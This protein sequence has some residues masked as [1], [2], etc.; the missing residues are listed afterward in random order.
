MNNLI[1]EYYKTAL[2]SIKRGNHNGLVINAKPLYFLSIFS[3]IDR[4][5]EV[6]DNKLFFSETLN[7]EYLNTCKK[8]QPEIEP[9]PFFKPFYYSKSEPF[10]H[11]KYKQTPPDIGPS[12]RYIREYIDYAYLD[13]AL[14]DLLQ[15]A[16]AREQYKEA[17]LRFFWN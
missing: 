10:Y 1:F 14:W 8:Y 11:L 9:T 3:L 6:Y 15:E 2:L 7:A 13:N 5:E 4:K 17:I 12:S 16:E